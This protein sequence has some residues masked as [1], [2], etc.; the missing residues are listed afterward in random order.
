M[1]LMGTNITI[2]GGGNGAFAAASHLTI[3]GHSVTLYESPQFKDSIKGICELGGINLRTLP[4]NG[5]KEGFA[6]LRCITTD[7]KKALKDA[8]IIFVIVPSFAHENIAKLSAPYLHNGQLVVTAPG[9]MYGCIH[10]AHIVKQSGNYSDIL[11]ADLD[12]MMYACRKMN[13]T[14]VW[15]RG[16]KHGLG[17]GVFPANKTSEVFER[18]HKIYPY[19]VKRDN[20]LATGIS[21]PNFAVHI[22]VML[23]NISNIDN[24]RD[25]L[26][27]RECFTPSIGLIVDAIDRE[28]MAFTREGI[29]SLQDL[30]TQDRE[31]YG[32]Q[33][34]SGN[35]VAEIQANN[36]I[37]PTS[38]LPL[39]KYHRYITEDVPY[40]L[41]PAIEL[42]ELFHLPHKTMS[43][44][45]D[46]ACILCDR[47]FYKE[48]ITLRSIGLEGLSGKELL[49]YVQYGDR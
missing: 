29:F 36:P 21:N 45:A 47:D 2:L 39:N 25:M 27:Y 12:C 22:P 41:I 13:E 17:C 48:A 4:S 35:S 6:R 11:Y 16:Y 31:W 49:D 23:F 3:E 44:L 14:S 18:I 5:L 24:K 15:L 9:N 20:V 28:R 34:A 30:L 1:L 38:K 8:E 46:T 40:G 10:F 19:F 7:I 37:Y 26:F 43:M 32:Y 33:G 42:L